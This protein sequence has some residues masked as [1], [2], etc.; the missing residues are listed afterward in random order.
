MTSSQIPF[1][2]PISIGSGP[3]GEPYCLYASEVDLQVADRGG[4]LTPLTYVDNGDGTLSFTT[5]TPLFK[6]QIG[7]T[8]KGAFTTFLEPPNEYLFTLDPNSY[9][10]AVSVDRQIAKAINHVLFAKFGH[11]AKAG[12]GTV[13]SLKDDTPPVLFLTPGQSTAQFNAA[14]YA[15][16][17]VLNWPYQFLI[18]IGSLAWAIGQLELNP[19]LPPAEQA[20]VADLLQSATNQLLHYKTNLFNVNRVMAL[21]G[22]QPWEPKSDC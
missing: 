15:P 9:L 10:E 2:A 1:C 17:A 13:L 18:L 11:A 5:N 6:E 19:P 14:Y 20:D 7:F 22:P 3:Q 4:W 8:L 12:F 21:L 16:A